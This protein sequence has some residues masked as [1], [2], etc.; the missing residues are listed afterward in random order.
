M[1]FFTGVG[2]SGFIAQ[3][4]SQTFVSTGSK[5]VYLNPTDALHG[6]LGIVSHTDMVV[7]F[8]KSG[9]TDELLRLVPY[10]KVSP[11]YPYQC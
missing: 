3:K 7:C 10:A 11:I 5:A 9:D 6:D 2:K 8:S 1:I 4:I